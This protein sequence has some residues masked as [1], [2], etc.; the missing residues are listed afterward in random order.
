MRTN[1]PAKRDVVPVQEL[2]EVVPAPLAVYFAEEAL[3][4][5][6]GLDYGKTLE[7]GGLVGHELPQQKLALRYVPQ[8]H[9][10]ARLGHLARHC[11]M[12]HVVI[13]F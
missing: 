4:H 5:A 11:A 8:A 10:A 6:C 12:R 7:D 1:L 2:L 13:F 9:A 3:R